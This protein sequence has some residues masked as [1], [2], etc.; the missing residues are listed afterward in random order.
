MKRKI[1]AIAITIASLAGIAAATGAA[2]GS[3]QAAAPHT[4]FHG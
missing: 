4:Y 3:A 2:A 1:A